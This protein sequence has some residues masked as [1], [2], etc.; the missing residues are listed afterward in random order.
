MR[1][2]T[3]VM[4]RPMSRVAELEPDGDHGCA[5]DHCEA[6]EPIDAGVVAV[7]DQQRAV[8]PPAAA[9]PYLSGA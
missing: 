8:E 9:Q 4:T 1:R 5:G 7:G 6:D 3:I 2:I